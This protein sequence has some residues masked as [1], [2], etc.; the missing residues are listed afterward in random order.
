MSKLDVIESMVQSF[1]RMTALLLDQE[2]KLEEAKDTIALLREQL[3]RREKKEDT[4]HLLL[5]EIK[6]NYSRKMEA[7]GVS[8]K[9]HQINIDQLDW[10]SAKEMAAEPE[11]ALLQ[12]VFFHLSE[13]QRQVDYSDSNRTAI[14]ITE[15]DSHACA[16]MLHA[17]A[18]AAKIANDERGFE[19]MDEDL[20][21]QVNRERFVPNGRELVRTSR[22]FAQL[23]VDHHTPEEFTA[24]S[25]A[26]YGNILPEYMRKSYW[27]MLEAADRVQKIVRPKKKKT[28][29]KKGKDS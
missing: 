17:C 22:H 7:E 24:S 8:S 16:A 26:E 13:Y 2:R 12:N 20:D 15:M 14:E 25:L 10:D 1:S 3:S 28:S 5:S 6:H 19:Y 4:R 29:K 9:L 11:M 18:L 27:E 21:T 23:V